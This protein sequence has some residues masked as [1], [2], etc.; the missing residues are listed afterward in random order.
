MLIGQLQ[1]HYLPWVPEYQTNIM[2][3]ICLKKDGKPPVYT[4][5]RQYT[6]TLVPRMTKCSHGKHNLVLE[7]TNRRTITLSH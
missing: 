1:K 5:M 4:H 2:F 3:N 7:H 6:I